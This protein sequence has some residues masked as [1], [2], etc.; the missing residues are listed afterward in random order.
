MCTT[1][2]IQCSNYSVDMKASNII[3]RSRIFS[4]LS[5]WGAC[6]AAGFFTNPL[7]T[8][9]WDRAKCS[10]HGDVWLSLFVSIIA[11]SIPSRLLFLVHCLRSFG[12][13]RSWFWGRRCQ[14][15][16]EGSTNGNGRSNDRVSFHG[17]LENNSRNNDND[18]TFGSIQYTWCHSTDV[19]KREKVTRVP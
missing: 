5:W 17:L 19:T 1:T 16:S 18:D 4:Y 12:L 2:N 13:G 10:A 8:G 15:I 11:L 7:R 3:C 14:G 9:W 6:D